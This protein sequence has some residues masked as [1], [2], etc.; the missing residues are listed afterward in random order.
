MPRMEISVSLAAPLTTT[1]STSRRAS[2]RSRIGRLRRVSA[3]ITVTEAGA[4]S[5]RCSKPAAVTTVVS[6]SVADQLRLLDGGRLDQ[7]ADGQQPDQLAVAHH[8]QVAQVVV[9]HHLHAVAHGLLRQHDDDRLGHDL[10][11]RGRIGG[12]PLQ[13]HLARIVALADDAHQFAVAHHRQRPD[14]LFRHQAQGVE[15]PGVG[16]DGVDVLLGLQGKQLGDG[17]HCGSPEAPCQGQQETG[18]QQHHQ[19]GRRGAVPDQAQQHPAQGRHHGQGGGQ[20]QHPAKG[21]GQQK[22]RGTGGDQQ[23]H[24]RHHAHRLQGADHE[25]CRGHPQQ[26]AEQDVV[27]VQLGGQPGVQHQAQAEHAGKRPR[28]S[29]PAT[30]APATSGA[31]SAEASTR[32]GKTAWAMASPSSA[33]PLSTRKQDSSAV[34]TATSTAISNAW[35]R[36]STSRAVTRRQDE[37]QQKDQGL[38]D[39]HAAPGGAVEEVAEVGTQEPAADADGDADQHHPREAIAEQIG[40]RPRR[41]H[42]GDDQE[43]A[44]RLHRRHGAQRQQGKEQQPVQGGIETAGARLALV[45]EYQQQVAPLE[46][47]HQQGDGGDSQQLATGLGGNGQDVAEDDGL[48][49]HRHRRQ[50]DQEQPA[51]KEGAEDQADDD[52][53]LES[54]VVPQPEHGASRRAAGEKGAQGQRQ[55]Q[56][57]GAGHAGHHGM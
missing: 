5:R 29:G 47:Q 4:S 19:G 17:F 44:H 34:G 16:G 9:G 10:A 41:H 56:Q 1:P 26:V 40:R 36:K 38:Q 11:D 33:Q 39:H 6:R 52:V 3:S 54:G 30:K 7:I 42:Q 32:P 37:G 55:P 22:G 48:D 23:R 27:Q 24:H 43:G 53:F 49:V 12:A 8:R 20:Q 25:G 45:E 14:V 2:P 46:Q 50:R 51:A 13:G 28:P 21:T 31:P 18:R 57:I 15:H 35:R